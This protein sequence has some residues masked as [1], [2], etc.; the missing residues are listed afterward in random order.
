VESSS[1]DALAAAWIVAADGIPSL[2]AKAEELS[3][4]RKPATQVARDA[5]VF[6]TS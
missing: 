4:P 2:L 6:V 5:K 1:A 3:A